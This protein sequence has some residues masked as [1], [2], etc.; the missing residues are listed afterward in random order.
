MR[1]VY[2]WGTNGATNRRILSKRFATTKKYRVFESPL[3]L[4][5]LS[6]RYYTSTKFSENTLIFKY[7]IQ[8]LILV[9]VF[10]LY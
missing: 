3:S 8:Y 9:F 5:K 4:T 2:K 7:I 1:V 6:Q 10:P